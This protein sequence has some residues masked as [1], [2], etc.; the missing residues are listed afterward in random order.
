[1]VWPVRALG[2]ADNGRMRQPLQLSRRTVGLLAALITVVIWTSFIVIA[3]ASVDPAREATLHPLD[4]AY[5]R[6]LGASA[7]LLPLGVKLPCH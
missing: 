2:P 6:I 3:R 1:M 7:V 4:L 5:A